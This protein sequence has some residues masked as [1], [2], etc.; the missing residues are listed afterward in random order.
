MTATLE[1]RADA[2]PEPDLARPAP[3]NRGEPVRRRGL[4]YQPALD[5]LRAIAVLAVL[6]YHADLPWAPGGFLGVD[7]FF[8]L[9]GFL[10][11]TLLLDANARHGTPDLRRFY[12][13][14]ARRLLPALF[15]VLIGSTLLVITLAPDAAGN[16]QRDLPAA[17]AY[18]TNW[19]YVL[20][21]QS[22][23]EATGR[24]PMLEHLWSLAVEEQFYLLWPWVFLL[25]WRLGR[26]RIVRRT[27]LIGAVLSTGAMLV[28][29]VANGYPTEADPSRVYFGTDTHVM[30]LLLGAA[31]ATAWIPTRARADLANRPR[32]IIDATGVVG[33]LLVA[34]VFWRV[35]EDSALLYRGGFLALS[36]LVA[37]IIVALTHPASRVG[38]I[39][40]SAPMRYLGTRSYGIYLWHWPIFLV[41]RPGLDVPLTGTA[42][43][44]LRLGLTLGIAELSYR[45]LETPIRQH[46]FRES[47]YRLRARM[48]AGPRPIARAAGRPV[49]LLTIV[50]VVLGGMTL[51]LYT[52]PAQAD[53]LDGVTSLSALP[54]QDAAEAPVAAVPPAGADEP[55][56]AEAP[57]LLAAPEDRAGEQ[58][59]AA[60]PAPPS[61][62]AAAPPGQL[63]LGES[64]LIGA[65]AS[66]QRQ[67]PDMVIDAEVGRQ[68][69]EMVDRIA[70]LAGAN[71]LRNEVVLHVGSNGY[72]GENS[73]A[74]MLDTLTAGGVQRIVVLTVS[75]PRRWQDPNNAVLASVVPRYPN[76]ILMD[77]GAEVRNNPDLVVADGV[78]PTG[79]GIS[80]FTELVGQG[81]AALQA[82]DT[83]AQP[84]NGFIDDEPILE[85]SLSA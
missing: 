82:Q 24:P 79:P 1:H 27:A 54:E 11:T 85:G 4:G 6:A 42:N 33:L 8:V 3:G 14:R 61:A 29:S 76:A 64:V 53:Y 65:S 75:V 83:A 23:F 66:L 21:D 7:I 32:M 16:Q 58:P 52:M 57:P 34:I 74:A 28:L 10:I 19:V 49:I 13:R 63:G 5:G 77:W 51:R 15:A 55:P 62:A 78:H 48:L 73:V 2:P 45:F 9:S 38:R 70:E 30:G 56:A 43:L 50:A 80:K 41:T 69:D 25:A 36:A 40:G 84:E 47:W 44:L 59:G 67:Y 35:S 81:L 71:A 18:V 39:I 20:T 31:L 12:V 17:L 26:S 72:V 37:V 22:Y 60:A 46:G 68:Q